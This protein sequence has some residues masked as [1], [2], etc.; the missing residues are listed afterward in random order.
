MGTARDIAIGI[1]GAMSRIGAKV[2]TAA[3]NLVPGETWVK[4]TE[5]GSGT[6]AV[7]LPPLT[8]DTL[9]AGPVYVEMDVA[10]AGDS[11]TVSELSGAGAGVLAPTAS[12]LTA[13]HDFCLYMPLPDRWVKWASKET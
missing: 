5:P 8:Q 11:V 1:G 3:T 13:L 6:Y 7:K 4:V 12:T 2:V 10:G 9:D